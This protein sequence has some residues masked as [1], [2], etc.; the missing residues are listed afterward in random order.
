ML[1]ILLACALLASAAVFPALAGTP[2]ED[3]HLHFD[4]DGKFRILNFS[5][6]QDDESLDDRVKLFLR[7]AV[8]TAQPDLIVLTGDNIYGT[9][10]SSSKTRAAIAEIMTVFE[11]LGVPVAIVFGNHDDEGGTSKEIQMR[12]YSSYDVSVSYD[13]GSVLDGCGTYNVPIYGSTE[14][15]KVKFNLWMFDTGS[16]ASSGYDHMRDSQLSWYVQ[17]SNEL[18]A[19]NGGK[20]VPSIAFQH[21]IVKEIFDALKK[22]SIGTSGAVRYNLSYYVLPDT[23]APGSVMKEH[24]CPSGGGDEFSVVKQ[25]GDVLAIVC[26]HDHTNCFIVPH[27]GIDLINTPGTGFYSYGDDAL[28]GA[29]II[30]IDEQS[31][32]Y[33]TEMLLLR[34][35]IEPQYYVQTG[36]RKYVKN[37]ALCVAQSAQYGSTEA[38]INAAYD[39]LYAAVDAANGG[40][41]AQR[42]DLNGGSTADQS[43]DNHYVVLAGYTLTESSAEAMRGL[44]TC[45]TGT[46]GDSGA[47]YDG[48]SANG[49]VWDLC[50]KNALAVAGTDG[51]VDLNVGTTGG[52][53]YFIA[54]Y[55]SSADALTEIRI[56]T[57]GPDDAID[58]DDFAGYTLVAPILGKNTGT[59]YADANKSAKGDFV[60]AL[61]RTASDGASRVPLDTLPLLTA[62]LWASKQ[63]KDPAAVYSEESAAALRSVLAEAD[64]ILRDL[65]NDRQTTVYDQAA[66]HRTASRITLCTQALTAGSFTV[67]FDAS[68]GICPETSRTYLFGSVYGTLPTATRSRYTLDGWYTE[69][70]GGRPVTADT[71]YDT[72]SDQT[73]YAHWLPDPD[74]IAGDADQTGGVDLLD[75]IALQRYLAGGWNVTVEFDHADVNADGKV[76]LRDVMLLRRYL[77]GGWNVD[78]V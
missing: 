33:S 10:I 24:P 72:L 32:T 8:C 28:R 31:G 5:D 2:A 15:D 75:V 61:Y 25:Q 21:I 14:T 59:S 44:S 60:Y 55:G 4:R 41:V 76:D 54:N 37:L 64:V 62:R 57:T 7:Q 19:A 34:D 50:N 36:T 71:V 51:A 16:N 23:A 11:P 78:L 18:K 1:C 63:L 39:R 49:L 29:R 45:Y 56:V 27:Q 17:K 47:Q 58:M 69:P 3:A 30:D 22:V 48:A 38:A 6:I 26:G 74:W 35:L 70:Q 68:G 73:W 42:V 12:Y 9:K 67:T 77:A 66:I 53:I 43:S 13:E 65:D 46:T 20:P 52:A 40:G